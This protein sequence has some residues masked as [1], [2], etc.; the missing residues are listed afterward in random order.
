[1]QNAPPPAPS[2]PPPPPSQNVGCLASSIAVA[3]GC[4]ITGAIIYGMIHQSD[5]VMTSKDIADAERR[6]DDAR[7][8]AENEAL[9]RPKT[10]APAATT[11]DP[12]DP[13]T[14]E[15]KKKFDAIWAAYDQL[16]PARRTKAELVKSWNT[17]VNLRKR[18]PEH[19]QLQL[20]LIEGMAFR[21]RMAPLIRP[22]TRSAGAFEQALV[23]SAD[24]AECRLWGSMWAAESAEDLRSFGFTDIQCADGKRW[25]L[26]S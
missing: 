3:L 26:K 2:P 17:A 20:E 16:P 13:E 10:T 22:P 9:F 12:P 15:A 6:A 24:P 19:L 5:R 1:M 18:S 11:E 21:K 23:P 25:P 8:Q 4:L 14:K 7:R